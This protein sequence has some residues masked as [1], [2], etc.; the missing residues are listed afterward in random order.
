MTFAIGQ[1]V[2]CIESGLPAR[3]FPNVPRAGRIYTVRSVFFDDFRKRVGIH[4][5]E[6]VN[7]PTLTRDKGM[8]EVGFAAKCFR[9]VV[10]RKTDIS[11]FVKMLDEVNN[12]Q[13]V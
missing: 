6:L 2:V 12:K 4:L 8:F 1:R 7:Q 10:E 5:A 13:L 9:P 11:I 3:N